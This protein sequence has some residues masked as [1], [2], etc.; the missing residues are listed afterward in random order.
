MKIYNKAME[1]VELKGHS[2]SNN[3]HFVHNKL[4]R[5]RNKNL[6]IRKSATQ[7]EDVS[8]NKPVPWVGTT[9]RCTI[10]NIE[11]LGIF[12]RNSNETRTSGQVSWTGSAM[13]T[14]YSDICMRSAYWYTNKE[15]VQSLCISALFSWL[16]L[17]V[18][19]LSHPLLYIPTSASKQIPFCPRS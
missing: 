5:K 15:R 17:Y 8:T 19:S 9:G 7:K 11:I 4:R 3:E 14:Q 12:N 1:L 13:E 18:R 10:A 6:K 16:P 2:S